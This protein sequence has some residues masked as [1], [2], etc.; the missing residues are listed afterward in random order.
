MHPQPSRGRPDWGRGG[1]GPADGMS[2]APQPGQLDPKKSRT[3]SLAFQGNRRGSLALAGSMRGKGA[4]GGLGKLDSIGLASG[5]T[6]SHEKLL[7]ELNGRVRQL[8]NT[9]RVEEDRRVQQARDHETC[10]S[11]VR[12]EVAAAQRRYH[13]ERDAHAVAQEELRRKEEQIVSQR[14]EIADLR[15]KMAHFVEMNTTGWATVAAKNFQLQRLRKYDQRHA[16]ALKQE[17]AARRM[18]ELQRD[19]AIKKV[20]PLEQK[21]IELEHRLGLHLDSAAGK[22]MEIAVLSQE[23]HQSRG[24]LN[25]LERQA[26]S[27]SQRLADALE[28]GSRQALELQD[29]KGEKG[30]L[31]SQVV[32]YREGLRDSQQQLAAARE[33]LGALQQQV[34]ELE[35]LHSEKDA[36]LREAFSTMREQEAVNKNLSGEVNLLSCSL[37]EQAFWRAKAERQCGAALAELSDV[38]RHSPLLD[39]IKYTQKVRAKLRSQKAKK[40]LQFAAHEAGVG[41]ED[42]VPHQGALE[43]GGT[44]R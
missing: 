38:K 10:V 14:E 26:Q 21:N 22:D 2:E 35:R 24:L 3:M 8:V 28:E 20:K 1:S 37:D 5:M 11:G 16:K 23:V 18:A 43:E 39:G 25:G 6:E 33:G 13:V 19:R 29:L 27:S 4:A 44:W 12:K 9:L 15:K 34:A 30:E 32:A 41:V 36:S 7:M 40:E 17:G 42:V 31:A